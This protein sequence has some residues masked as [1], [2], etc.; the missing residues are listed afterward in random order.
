MSARKPTGLAMMVGDIVRFLVDVWVHGLALL[1]AGAVFLLLWSVGTWC[2]RLV[3]FPA[4]F[5]V[6]TV[7][8]PLAV[9]FTAM[10]FVRKVRPGCYAI[11]RAEALRWIV[12]ESLLLIVQRSFLRGY[13]E[14]FGPQRYL[15][16]RL[17]GARIDTSFFMG[18]GA[19][20]LDPWVLEVGRGVV[21]GAFSVICGHALE[22]DTLIVRR[23]KIGD[24]AT[25]G[26]RSVILPGVEIG[27]EAIVGAGA[28]VTK[29]THI[30]PREIW[31]GVPARKIGVVGAS[32][33]EKQKLIE[34]VLM[35]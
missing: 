20:V 9:I 24:G 22:G 17:L 5:A 31:A 26:V 28:V 6:M 30:P 35:M 8:F 34:A 16:Y 4:A 27:K 12:A 21:I 14:D 3:A 29:D 2:A 11:R 15:F 33:A 18:G 25:V 10:L 19:R 23:V 7:A 32:D 1:P 13:L